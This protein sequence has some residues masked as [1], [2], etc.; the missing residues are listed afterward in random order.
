M[1]RKRFEELARE[2]FENLPEDLSR[3]MENVVVVVEDSPG[4][5]VRR[6]FRLGRD[7]LLLGLYE[8]VPLS[9]RGTHY[10]AY[11]VAPDKISLFQKNIEKVAKG[12]EEIAARIREVLIH[13]IAHHFGMNEQQIRDAGY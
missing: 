13:E 5:E 8:G 2:A 4:E 9:R 3:K 7:G 10:G 1:E 6:D 12:E 11:P